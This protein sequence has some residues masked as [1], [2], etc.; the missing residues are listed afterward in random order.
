MEN[1]KMKTMVAGLCR[2][3]SCLCAPDAAILL[4]CAWETERSEEK[5]ALIERRVLHM[6]ESFDSGAPLCRKTSGI[7]VFLRGS[8]AGDSGLH[9]AIREGV[10]TAGETLCRLDAEE[11]E[12]DVALTLYRLPCR[13]PQCLQTKK[14]TEES[15]TDALSGFAA[16]VITELYD[17]VCTPCIMGVGVGKT[18]KEAERAAIFAANVR[19]IG[20]SGD[21][22]EETALCRRLSRQINRLRLGSAGLFGNCTAL[23]VNV[24]IAKEPKDRL[25]C[26]VFVTCHASGRQKALIRP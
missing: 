22:P 17:T 25:F 23:A 14:L 24:K 18:E 5:K 3:S 6:K 20:E 15:F 16:G 7:G 8:A 26:S 4:E 19:N 13:F 12:G 21:F 11:E 1:A 2:D 10:H 9:A